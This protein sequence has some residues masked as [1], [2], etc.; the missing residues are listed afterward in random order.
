M[1]IIGKPNK[2]KMIKIIVNDSNKVGF[3]CCTK[4]NINI[5]PFSVFYFL[6]FI[7][8]RQLKIKKLLTSSHC[9]KLSD[10][11]IIIRG[12]LTMQIEPLILLCDSLTHII[13]IEK[14]RKMFFISLD[15]KSVV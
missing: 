1:A 11:V 4:S 2:I 13:V 5:S 9:K 8:C 6:F 3:L 12:S 15:R 14:V 10:I 7:L